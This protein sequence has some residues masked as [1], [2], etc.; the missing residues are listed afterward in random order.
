MLLQAHEGLSDR[1]HVTGSASDLRWQ[2][3]PAS[4]PEPR[5]STDRPSGQ[6][7]RLRASVRREGCSRHQG[8]RHDDRA[9]KG[10]A[11][12]LDSTPIY[13]AVATE[14][15]I[16]SCEPRCESCSEPSTRRKSPRQQV[17]AALSRDDDY[18]TSGK[19]PCDWDDPVAQEPRRRP[20]A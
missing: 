13:D 3:A 12:V 19:P 2:A 5:P 8:R 15:T 18:A 6:R 4:T 20:R 16:T 17:R 14:D 7:N 11:R 1:E 9:M 10:R